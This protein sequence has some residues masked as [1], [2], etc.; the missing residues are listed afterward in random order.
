MTCVNY[1][2]RKTES[3]CMWIP[4]C[5]FISILFW[6]VSGVTPTATGGHCNQSFH[7]STIWFRLHSM[8]LYSTILHHNHS[9]CLWSWKSSRSCN[10][11]SSAHKE[12]SPFLDLCKTLLATHLIH[13]SKRYLL[14]K[15]SMDW[16][17]MWYSF[18]FP[19]ATI[20]KLPKGGHLWT[21]EHL[22]GLWPVG[23]DF[24][25]EWEISKTD[26]SSKW[27]Q[28][29]SISPVDVICDQSGSEAVA[30]HLNR[31]QAVFACQA[32]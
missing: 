9:K 5:Q 6:L 15:V 3:K 22:H 10:S 21:G 20:V 12:D 32:I 16:L 4:H 31:A 27:L 14:A 2:C 26:I 18:L 13:K 25:Q 23:V 28:K 30:D 19:S 8:W 24:V 29:G 1:P 11:R 17:G 7:L